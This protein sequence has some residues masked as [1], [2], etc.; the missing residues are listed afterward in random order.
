V[1]K[2]EIRIDDP[3]DIILPNYSFT[4][5]IEIEPPL[6]LLLVERLAIGY[7]RPAEAEGPPAAGGGQMP[8]AAEESAEAPQ[9]A[10]SGGRPRTGG[11]PRRG[12]AYAEKILPGGGVER[13]S[14]RVEPYGQDFVKVISGLAEGDELKAQA[15]PPVS[16]RNR[17][18]GAAGAGTDP[19]PGGQRQDQRQDA[20][21][22]RV[23]PM[24]PGA[25]PS[26]GRSS[27]TRIPGG[28]G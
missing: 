17:Q 23:M 15:G 18:N 20:S 24:M 5:E 10:E 14:V 27:G 12:E 13:V 8:Q 2:A 9:A 11:G 28:G 19:G 25:G 26:G 7:E 16:G 4:G 21:P 1:V 3:P 6:T 22:V